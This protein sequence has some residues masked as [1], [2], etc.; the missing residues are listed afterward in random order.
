MITRIV[1]AIKT[2]FLFRCIHYT[3]DQK[4]GF[5][6]QVFKGSVTEEISHKITIPL[7]AIKQHKQAGYREHAD[8]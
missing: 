7:L 2:L 8:F 4:K 3:I 5:F 6:K 1:P